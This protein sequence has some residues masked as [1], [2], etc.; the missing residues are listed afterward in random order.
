MAVRDEYM[1]NEVIQNYIWDNYNYRPGYYAWRKSYFME[2]SYIHAACEDITY[3]MALRM[4]DDPLDIIR[5]YVNESKMCLAI[6]QKH[7]RDGDPTAVIMF[8][9]AVSIGE[10]VERLLEDMRNGS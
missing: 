4:N 10:E 7:H 5:D 9:T 8:Q 2:Y 1:E 6:A 3:A